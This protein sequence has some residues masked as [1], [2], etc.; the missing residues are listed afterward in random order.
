MDP[1]SYADDV[2]EEEWHSI[3]QSTESSRHD[4]ESVFNDTAKL[5]VSPVAPSYSNITSSSNDAECELDAEEIL[6]LYQ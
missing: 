4:T 5:D 6:G 3:L 2:E 1:D